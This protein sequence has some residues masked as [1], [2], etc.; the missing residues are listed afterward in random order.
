MAWL[1]ASWHLL[2]LICLKL[3]P[4]TQAKITYKLLVLYEQLHNH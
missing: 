4:A 1:N 2:A 3:P